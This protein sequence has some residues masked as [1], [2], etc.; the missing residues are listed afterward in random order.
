MSAEHIL[1]S[2]TDLLFVCGIGFSIS[3]VPILCINLLISKKVKLQYI[4]ITA[5]FSL[6]Y[7]LGNI[8]AYLYY[9]I[10][11]GLKNVS[12]IKA[13]MWTVAF[14]FVQYFPAVVVFVKIAFIKKRKKDVLLNVIFSVLTVLAA[15]LIGY[16]DFVD[17]N[18][19]FSSTTLLVPGIQC[20]SAIIF[21]LIFTSFRW[22]SAEER[23]KASGEPEREPLSSVLGDK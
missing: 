15:V 22:T 20:L 6:I 16:I 17:R 18:Q 10:D 8:F 7:I 13:I 12:Y 9:D 1:K 21:I 4:L 3:I 23:A 14:I 5:F 2:F 11:D 19:Y